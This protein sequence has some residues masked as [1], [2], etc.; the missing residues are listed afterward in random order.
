VHVVPHETP[1]S[2]RFVGKRNKSMSKDSRTDG[3]NN[4]GQF[5]G[6]S[7]RDFMLWQLEVD[8]TDIMELENGA[9]GD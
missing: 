3:M 1:G 6:W 7:A 4:L 8:D 2:D 9:N 5:D